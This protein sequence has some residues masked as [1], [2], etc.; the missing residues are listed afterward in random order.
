MCRSC[1]PTRFVC[2]EKIAPRQAEI[3]YACIITNMFAQRLAK[4]LEELEVPFIN[5][6]VTAVGHADHI[7]DAIFGLS[8]LRKK[9]RG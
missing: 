7:I 8:T 1:P 4:Q 2:Y 5:D 6:F 3:N 9:C